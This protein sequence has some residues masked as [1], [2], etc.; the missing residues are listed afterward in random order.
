M[1]IKNEKLDA[2]ARMTSWG[3]LT[4][5]RAKGTSGLPRMMEMCNIFFHVGD[6]CHI[7]IHI[8]KIH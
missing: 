6:S 8:V 4:G 5:E 1:E 3:I 2:S 7:C